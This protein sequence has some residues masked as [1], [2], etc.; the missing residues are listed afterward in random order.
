MDECDLVFSALKA[1]TRPGVMVDVGAH[2]GLALLPFARNGWRVIAAEPDSANRGKLLEAVRDM[3]N[4]SVDPR[5]VS[6][7][8]MERVALFRSE[9]ST[10]ISG[11][12]AFHPTHVEAETV[13]AQTAADLLRANSVVKVDFLKIDT[14]GY[15][16][17]VLQG[18]PWE[19][20][21][22]TVIVCEFEDG[23]SLPLGYAWREMADLLVAQGYRVIV[24]E[25]YPIVR[26]GANHRWRNFSD[27]PCL[28]SDNHGWGNLIAV[29]DDAVEKRLRHRCARF[30]AY[31][32]IES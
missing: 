30:R 1:D 19:I 32:Q 8:R 22:P 15:D 26:Y 28:L 10:G 14:E 6:N 20:V 9:V 7:K 17:F 25:W 21:L 12:S 23:K 11:L 24:S 13:A 29:R 4:V 16:F 31:Q 18:F 5:A 2:V 27:Y 3:P